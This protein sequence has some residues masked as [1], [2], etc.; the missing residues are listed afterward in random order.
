MKINSKIYILER[1][2]VT[3]G[4]LEKFQ[5]CR[6]KARLFL[7]GWSSRGDSSALVQGNVGHAVLE[8]AYEAIRTGKMTE[9]PTIGD[10]RK[11]TKK[12]ENQW[13]QE[14]TRPGKGQ[15]E[16]LET[17]LAL[18]EATIPAYFQYWKKDLKKFQWVKVENSFALPVKLDS[19]VTIPVRGKMDGVYKNPRLWLFETKFKSLI[20]EDDITEVLPVDKQVN[21]YMLVL[22]EEMKTTPA[23][24]M[25]NVIRRTSIK[26]KKGESLQAYASRVVADIKKRPEFYFM[27]FEVATVKSD[28]EQ[29]RV[30]LKDML[31]DYHAWYTGKAGHYRCSQSC[32]TKYGRCEYLPVCSSGNYSMLE[33][34]K[35]VFRELE[36]Y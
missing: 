27:R 34:R 14:R 28:I 18:I 8:H 11:I 13:H 31:K 26:I 9:L 10:V 32:V 1:D 25:Y 6:E 21:T 3:Q 24:V 15:L 2:G 36:D 23:G 33:R 7:E 22:A 29:F 20:N 19:G 4:L 35:K 5:M 16:M 17:A 30:E 12:I